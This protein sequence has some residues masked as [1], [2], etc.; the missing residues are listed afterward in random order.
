MLTIL[1]LSF[2]IPG[3]ALSVIAIVTALA[4]RRRR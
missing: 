3:L 4:G 2:A 1:A